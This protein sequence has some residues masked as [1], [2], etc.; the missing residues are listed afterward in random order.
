MA[1]WETLD[2]IDDI[3]PFRET[4]KKKKAVYKD[5]LSTGGRQ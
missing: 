1:F 2:F 4:S 3:V 5:T